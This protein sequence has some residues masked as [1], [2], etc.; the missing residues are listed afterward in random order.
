[1][2]RSISEEI[3]LAVAVVDITADA[4]AYARFWAEIPVVEI[5]GGII[6]APFTLSKL[7]A[8]LAEAAQPKV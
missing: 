2:L 3:E 6:R 5:A 7:R 1:M 8:M 4:E